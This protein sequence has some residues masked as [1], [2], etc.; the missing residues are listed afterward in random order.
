MDSGSA[1]REV[2]PTERVKFWYNISEVHEE[3]AYGGIFHSVNSLYLA[4]HSSASTSFPNIDK[5]D[6]FW[7]INSHRQLNL[8]VLSTDENAFALAK[9]SLDDPVLDILLIETKKIEHGKIQF[10]I[11]FIH[12]KNRVG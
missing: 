11:Y 4:S 8:V 10:Y 7:Q 3:N 5:K 9:N 6:V 2:F 1:I 12:V